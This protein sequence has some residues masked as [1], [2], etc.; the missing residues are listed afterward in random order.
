MAIAI[1]IN[2]PS[3]KLA[4][5]EKIILDT[6]ILLMQ[7]YSNPLEKD[8]ERKKGY[9]N[10]INKCI[11]NK[12]KLYTTQLNIYESFHMI[13]K[14][15]LD[16][17]NA[18]NGTDLNIKNYHKIEE[19]RIK[20][21]SDMEI[22]YKCLSNAITILQDYTEEHW[23][24]EYIPSNNCLDLYDFALVKISEA[25]GIS[26]ILTNDSDFISDIDLIQNF[27]IFTQNNK[28]LNFF[29]NI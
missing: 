26:S 6:N 25:N 7:F 29:N 10:F 13:D 4:K 17:Y 18:V 12:L 8:N 2:A 22:F 20:V 3:L 27:N 16:I 15:N 1:N 14:I 19:E 5:G 23:I 28:I 24:D 11:T 21:H 9:Q